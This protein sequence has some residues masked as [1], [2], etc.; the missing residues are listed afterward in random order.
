VLGTIITETFYIMVLDP[1]II[2][3]YGF[4]G[5]YKVRDLYIL[6]FKLAASATVAFFLARAACGYVLVGFGW[7]SVVVHAIMCGAMTPLMMVAMNA[8]SEE[9]RYLFGI[10]KNKLKHR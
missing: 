4:D 8:R 2:Y 1:Y 3:R 7:F 10:V 5:R 6:L 9:A